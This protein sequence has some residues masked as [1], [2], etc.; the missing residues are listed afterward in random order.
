MSDYGMQEAEGMTYG[1]L[2]EEKSARGERCGSRFF[3]LKSCVGC[4]LCT[5]GGWAEPPSC[6][7][8]ALS[9]AVCFVLAENS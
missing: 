5:W 8:V 7:T 1:H 9:G 2:T 4:C 6:W 3:S